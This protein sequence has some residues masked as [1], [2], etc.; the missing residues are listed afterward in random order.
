MYKIFRRFMIALA[1][2]PLLSGLSSCTGS[3]VECK[4]GGPADYGFFKDSTE[5]TTEDVN[6]EDFDFGEAK[7]DEEKEQE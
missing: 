4:Y 5:D 6:H 3:R 1:G 2:I 7:N